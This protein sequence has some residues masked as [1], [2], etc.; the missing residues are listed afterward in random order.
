MYVHQNESLSVEV[1]ISSRVQE[2]CSTD[3]KKV[4]AP[5]YFSFFFVFWKLLQIPRVRLTKKTTTNSYSQLPSRKQAN[6][7]ENFP[8]H[9]WS[10][11]KYPE[12]ITCATHRH[13]FPPSSPS[14]TNTTWGIH[15]M[16][17]LVPIY[18]QETQYVPRVLY[19]KPHRRKPYTQ[20]WRLLSSEIH[21]YLELEGI[22]FYQPCDRFHH[23]P[24]PPHFFKNK[25]TKP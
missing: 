10:F 1:C 2:S 16:V 4:D 14:A 17:L 3:R 24:P 7:S 11:P 15:S 9:F 25:D 5:H 6:I 8:G 13:D 19:N 12:V 23:L 20:L 18:Q 22:E 21:C